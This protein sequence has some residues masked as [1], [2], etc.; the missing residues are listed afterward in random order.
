[1]GKPREHRN[2]VNQVNVSTHSDDR[3][4]P[5]P[6]NTHKRTPSDVHKVHN[7]HTRRVLPMTGQPDT[8]NCDQVGQLLGI[9]PQ[10]ARQME[11][12]ARLP[13]HRGVG[14]WAWVFDRDEVLEWLGAHPAVR[15]TILCAGS[16]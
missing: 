9:H 4:T 13:A 1:M 5:L 6:T 14:Q 12:E 2:L 8:L 11:R 7:V 16:R 15:D 3:T 10:V